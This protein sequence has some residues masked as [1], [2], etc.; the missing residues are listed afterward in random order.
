MFFIHNHLFMPYQEVFI[1]F[2]EQVIQ[3][4]HEGSFAKLTL[5]KTIGKQNLKNIFVKPVYDKDN[6]KVKVKLSYRMTETK[7]EESEMTLTE[8]YE[9]LKPY[10]KTTFFTVILFSTE[11]DVTFKINKKGAG[12]IVETPPTFQNVE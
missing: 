9:F 12:N 8:A 10:L 3:S 4:Y 6:L 7:D 1:F 5:A 11:K 2:W